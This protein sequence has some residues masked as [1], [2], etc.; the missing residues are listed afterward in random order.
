MQRESDIEKYISNEKDISRCRVSILESISN[1]SFKKRKALWLEKN[2]I[3]F[4]FHFL[5]VNS[6]DSVD[7]AI[8]SYVNNKYLFE[9]KFLNSL[10]EDNLSSMPRHIIGNLF[11]ILYKKIIFLEKYSSD[12]LGEFICNISPSKSKFV[13][14]DIVAYSKN[15]SY[16]DLSSMSNNNLLKV[17]PL[18]VLKKRARVQSIIMSIGIFISEELD[19]LRESAPFD[20]SKK[21]KGDFSGH[22]GGYSSSFLR[23]LIILNEKIDNIVYNID[24]NLFKNYN[25]AISKADSVV[26]ETCG[27]N[28]YIKKLKPLEDAL[29]KEYCDNEVVFNNNNIVVPCVAFDNQPSE[30]SRANPMLILPI[31]RSGNERL[32]PFYY[33]IECMGVDI[34]SL[35]YGKFFNTYCSSRSNDGSYY[36]SMAFRNDDIE[37]LKASSIDRFHI[38]YEN[39]MGRLERDDYSIIFNNK[40]GNFIPID[41]DRSCIYISKTRTDGEIMFSAMK[42][43]N[44]ILDSFKIDYFEICSNVEYSIKNRIQDRKNTIALYTDVL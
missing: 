19:V 37:A 9:N 24:N 41:M 22:E 12:F 26:S 10:V 23:D 5:N 7:A 4:P 13:F 29:R 15:Y 28:R 1:L 18:I 17:E 8:Y 2:L 3:N 33:K 44:S 16:D 35:L 39:L 40:H 31:N 14:D 34:S 6:T 20:L 27:H 42:Y 11:L 43:V 30:G 38:F 21:L 32:F 25:I 36:K